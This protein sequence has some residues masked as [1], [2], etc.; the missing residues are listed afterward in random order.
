M[1]QTNEAVT[2][3]TGERSGPQRLPRVLT[4]FGGVLLT[5]SCI[6]PA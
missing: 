5:L 6:T 4:V 2:S 1:S 3:A